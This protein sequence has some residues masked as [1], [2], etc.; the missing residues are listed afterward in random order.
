MCVCACAFVCVQ[1]YAPVEQISS[2]VMTETASWA[3]DS[4]TASETAPMDQMNSAA[5]IVCALCVRSFTDDCLI[6]PK[7]LFLIFVCFFLFNLRHP[8][9]HNVCVCVC[10]F[11]FSVDDV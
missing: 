5:K 7:A 10:T 8:K 11:V 1:L 3:A 6:I 4:V 9:V 2:N